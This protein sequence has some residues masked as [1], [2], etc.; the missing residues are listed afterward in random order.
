MYPRPV[1]AV[2]VF[3]VLSIA[4]A[5][6]VLFVVAVRYAALRSGS[7][8]RALLNQTWLAAGGITGWIAV[9]AWAA[10][11]GVLARFGARPPPLNLMLVAALGGSVAFASSPVASTVVDA[12]PLW[13]LIGFQAFR[14]PL[15]LIMHEGVKAGVIPP[16]MSFLGWNFDILTGMSACFV[17]PVVASGRAPR[18]LVVAWN[19]GGAALL[20]VIVG[21]ALAST[22]LIRAFGD[23]AVNTFIAYWPFAPLPAEIVPFALAGHVLVARW[24]LR[25]PP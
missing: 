13:A 8:G 5:L 12:V 15:E 7:T 18:A 24:L 22:P 20:S 17:A 23:G 4:L 9:I 2:V 19:G 14:L 10:M 16:Q 21:V 3:G 25:H 11:S 6:S 1:P